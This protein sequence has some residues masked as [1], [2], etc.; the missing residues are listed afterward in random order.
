MEYTVPEAVIKFRQGFGRL[1]R[2]TTDVGVVIILD[3]RIIK[4]VYGRIFLE[5]L[6]VT[7]TIS[8]NDEQLWEILLNWFQNIGSHT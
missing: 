6:P 3:N 1:I 7:A 2:S 8:D 5:S 4:K